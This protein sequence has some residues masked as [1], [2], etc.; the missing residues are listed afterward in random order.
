M[1]KILIIFFIPLILGVFQSVFYIEDIKLYLQKPLKKEDVTNTS[2]IIDAR[3]KLASKK[4]PIKN[5]IWLNT[6]NWNVQFKEFKNKYKQGYK[7]IVCC[8]PG[9]DSGKDIAEKLKSLGYNF[10]DVKTL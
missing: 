5:A 10:I 2:I 7:I 1:K 6:E 8:A 4:E 9:C 3:S